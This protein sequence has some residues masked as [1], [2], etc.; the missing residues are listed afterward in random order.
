LLFTPAVRQRQP[1]GELVRS[2]VGCLTIK[3]HH[4][5][6]H[7]GRAPQL[8]APPIAHRRDFDLVR[9]TTDGFFEAMNIHVCQLSE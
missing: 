7:A 6:W 8:G 9:A 3:R 5:G 2:F 4:R 1:L